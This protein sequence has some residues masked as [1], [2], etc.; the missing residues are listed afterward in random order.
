MHSYALL[1]KHTTNF[2]PCH[3]DAW[4]FIFITVFQNSR[5]VG[6][7]YMPSRACLQITTVWYI[8]TT[9]YYS[10]I[11]KNSRKF[12]EGRWVWKSLNKVKQS[13]FQQIHTVHFC[14]RTGSSFFINLYL[15]GSEYLSIDRD[16]KTKMWAMTRQKE[17]LKGH[18]EVKK[19]WVIKEDR[20]QWRWKGTGAGRYRVGERGER[21]WGKTQYIWKCHEKF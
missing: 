4:A 12:Q 13:Q 8:H 5:R 14:S 3:R 17:A 20:G 10:V 2:M 15:H 18:K 16:H 1:G 21:R 11:N 19:A 6:S 9:G 7:P